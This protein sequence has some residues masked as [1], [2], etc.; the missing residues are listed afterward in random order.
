MGKGGDWSSSQGAAK[1]Q[2][3]SASLQPASF[4]RGKEERA[5]AT[6]RQIS[7]MC[8]RPASPK[9]HQQQDANW[10]VL[11]RAE[12]ANGAPLDMANF[13]ILKK[14]GTGSS[15]TVYLVK[16][17]GDLA[18]KDAAA[19]KARFALKIFHKRDFEKK[20]RMRRVLTEHSILSDTD[21]PFIVSLY[22]TFHQETTVAFLME[23]CWHGDMYQTLQRRPEGRFPEQQAK[24]YAAQVVAALQYLHVQGY[25]YRD[26]KPENIL[27]CKGGHVKLTD[28][29]L[30]RAVEPPSMSLASFKSKGGHGGH[31][32]RG[33]GEP[34]GP[35]EEGPAP[36]MGLGGQ[37]RRAGL[38]MVRSQ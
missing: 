11:A 21:H 3:R 6:A 34:E 25:I 35:L 38:G 19:A 18:A 16:L 31:G 17:R 37:R 23:H 1:Y 33:A 13:T 27:L 7:A 14:L 12:K 8:A 4:A 32:G 15:A 10:A 2:V 20:N 29:D 22:R 30:S 26:L 28:F 36:G 9:P 5:A 24:V